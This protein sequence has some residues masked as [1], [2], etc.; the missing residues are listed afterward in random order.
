VQT[1][2]QQD[3]KVAIAINNDYCSKCTICQSIC[4]YEAISKDEKTNQFTIDLEKC[5]VC[6]LCAS[7]CPSEA[8]DLVYYSDDSL[9]SYSKKLMTQKKA[10]NLVLTCRGSSPAPCEMMELLK[11]KGIEKFVS[12]RLPCVGRVTPEFL[13]ET[14]AAGANKIVVMQCEEG[15][16]RFKKGNEV[17]ANKVKLTQAALAQ[18]G[19]KEDTLSFMQVS[20][21]AVYDTQKCVGCDKCVFI[22]PYDAIEAEPL[23]TPEINLDRCVG[24]GA[25]ALVCPHLAIQ[26]KNFEYEPISKLVHN[27]GSQAKKMKTEGLTPAVLV[28]C[29]Q[30]S[31][32]SALDTL[33]PTALPKNIVLM[34]IPCFKGLDP[35][36]VVEALHAGFDGVL[37][38]TCAEKDCKL[39]EGKATADLNA[40]V[41]K[42]ALGKLGLAERFE[43]V[44]SSPRYVGDF[45]AKLDAFLTKLSPLKEIGKGAAA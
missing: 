24:C 36:H 42:K 28:F 39:E 30:W 8:I 44:T 14:V 41:L 15:F 11:Q 20:N 3:L 21:K 22:C 23:A 38:V 40:A 4:P 26:L 45:S 10:N 7:A 18:L 13:L 32:F 25:C 2:N 6:G 35:S 33:N 12:I 16:C 31:E 37:A 9:V 34:E 17:N 43:L 1:Q 19:Y 29:C 27:C 5:Q